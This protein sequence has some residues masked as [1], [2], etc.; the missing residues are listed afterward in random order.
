MVFSF[1]KTQVQALDRTSTA[2][3]MKLGRGGTMTH[4]HKRQGT[5]DLFAAMN[6]ETGE[7]LYTWRRASGQSTCSLSSS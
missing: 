3:A 5:T 2:L 6:A 4:D 7:V 1:E